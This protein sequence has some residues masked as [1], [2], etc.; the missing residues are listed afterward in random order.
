MLYPLKFKPIIKQTI[1]GGNKLAF[2]SESEKVKTSIGESWEISGVQENISVVSEGLLA[3]N[4]LEEL[5]EIYM[6]E[7]VGDKVYEK[8]GIEFPLLIKYIDACDNLSIQVHPDDAIAKERH[9]AYGKTEM[10]YVVDAAKDAQLIMGFNKETDKSEYLTRLQNNTLTEILNVEQIKPDDCF[11]IPA[12]TVHAIGKGC[13]IAEIQQTSDITYRIY[14]YDRRDKEGNSRELHTELATDVID[15]SYQKKHNI[16][17]HQHKNHTEELVNCNYF[18]TNILTFDKEIEKDYFKID[19]FVIYMC[20]EGQFT[21]V[22]NDDQFV[23]VKKGE[24]V[25]LPACFKSIFLIPEK[26][27]KVLEVYIK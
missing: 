22:Y 23:K 24:T 10:W 17:V 2:K 12:G 20:L 16:N 7:L 8:F 25:L 18:T 19:S 1:W 13:Y 14:D 21:I 4:N 3:D 9:Q 5:I 11:F 26:E 6:G 15:F 27:A